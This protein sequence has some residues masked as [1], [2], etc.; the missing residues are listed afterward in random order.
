MGRFVKTFWYLQKCFFCIIKHWLQ[1]RNRVCTLYFGKAD[2]SP[3][4]RA[5]CALA[6]CFRSSFTNAGHI[7][8]S[9]YETVSGYS[10]TVTCYCLHRHANT[11]VLREQD[12]WRD[13]AGL[14]QP[15]DCFEDKNIVSYMARRWF[16]QDKKWHVVADRGAQP[17]GPGLSWLCPAGV[18]AWVRPC[19]LLL[20]AVPSLGSK[21]DGNQD[22]VRY[23]WTKTQWHGHFKGLVT[24]PYILF[25]ILQSVL[26]FVL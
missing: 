21:S 25:F 26:F 14:S 23:M 15:E 1:P 9:S 2:T 3:P 5:P 16:L 13:T 4:S 19:L 17:G 22:G 10:H 7:R 12:T 11:W 6:E 8:F 18:P 20:P 24:L